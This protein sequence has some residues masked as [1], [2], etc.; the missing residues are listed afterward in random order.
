MNWKN[1]LRRHKLQK[2]QAF[3]VIEND[4][5]IFSIFNLNELMQL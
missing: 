1:G 5:I 3:K 4:G 2:N